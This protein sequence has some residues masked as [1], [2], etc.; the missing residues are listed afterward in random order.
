MKRKTRNIIAVVLLPLIFI[1]ICIY[2]YNLGI[3]WAIFGFLTYL[4]DFFSKDRLCD[5]NL[6]ELLYMIPLWPLFLYTRNEWK[7]IDKKR[8]K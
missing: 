4:L 5:D 8:K 1:G 6:T 7:R 3:L 2:N